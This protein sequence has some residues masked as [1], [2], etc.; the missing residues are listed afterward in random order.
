MKRES[1]NVSGIK[2]KIIKRS[3]RNVRTDPNRSTKEN[4]GISRR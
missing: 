4:Y 1:E 2:L 3:E